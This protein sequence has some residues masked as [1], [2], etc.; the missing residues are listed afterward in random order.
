MN[1]IAGPV[2]ETRP[3]TTRLVPVAD[4]LPGVGDLAAVDEAPDVGRDRLEGPA[5]GR[6]AV[7][8][9]AVGGDDDRL[10]AATLERVGE[11]LDL[12]L[13]RR[14]VEAAGG[15]DRQVEAGLVRRLVDGAC[16]WRRLSTKTYDRR[17]RGRPPSG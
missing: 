3:P 4:R 13:G 7:E 16:S 9:V 15:E 12:G 5:E 10:Q 14:V 6:R 1:Q 17:R 2:P 8:G 11:L